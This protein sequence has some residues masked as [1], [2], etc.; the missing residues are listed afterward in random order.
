MVNGSHHP[1]RLLSISQMRACA[2]WMKQ[3]RLILWRLVG[4]VGLLHLLAYTL[5][6]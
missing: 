4:I 1:G 2:E 5:W 6:P 3:A